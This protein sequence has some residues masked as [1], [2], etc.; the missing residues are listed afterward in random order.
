MSKRVFQIN[1]SH[2]LLFFR[3]IFSSH[4]RQKFSDSKQTWFQCLQKVM[5]NFFSEDK[6]LFHRSGYNFKLFYAI[7]GA[8]CLT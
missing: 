3:L 5:E 1:F 4:L 2:S 7:F 6:I 8:L